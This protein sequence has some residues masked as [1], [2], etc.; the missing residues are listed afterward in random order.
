MG[1]SIYLGTTSN[2]KPWVHLQCASFHEMRSLL[3]FAAY[4]ED[5][6]DYYQGIKEYTQ[7]MMDDPLLGYLMWKCCAEDVIT[8][9]EC[10][11]LAVRI[12]ELMPLVEAS[13]NNKKER[14]KEEEGALTLRQMNTLLAAFLSSLE[15][16]DAKGCNLGWC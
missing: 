12:R 10:H 1:M 2:G 6:E 7:E 8:A 5:V 15:R 13:Y 3:F 9:Y 16:Q 4:G 14:K 11:W